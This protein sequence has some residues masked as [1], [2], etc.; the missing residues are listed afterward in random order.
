[1]AEAKVSWVA[2]KIKKFGLRIG[3][4]LTIVDGKPVVEWSKSDFDSYMEG[5]LQDEK[6]SVFIFAGARW[7][8]KERTITITIKKEPNKALAQTPA[9]DAPVAPDA[10]AAYL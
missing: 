1:M 2:P 8:I 7:L 9:A 4:R 10:G 3:D 6:S 5:G